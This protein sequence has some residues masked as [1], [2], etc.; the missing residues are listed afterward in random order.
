MFRINYSRVQRYRFSL[1]QSNWELFPPDFFLCQKQ[2]IKLGRP[3]AV[4]HRQVPRNNDLSYRNDIQV[5]QIFNFR[6]IF[7]RESNAF[8]PFFM[9]KNFMTRDSRAGISS[10]ERAKKMQ[11]RLKQKGMNEKIQ[12]IMQTNSL[13]G[14]VRTRCSLC[15][16]KGRSVWIFASLAV[17]LCHACNAVVFPCSLNFMALPFSDFFR[18]FI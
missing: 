16:P 6:S 7:E 8:S 11:E 9:H 15:W 1:C 12:F 5:Q 17:L 18:R 3:C 2:I 13:S 14:Y 10:R 4:S